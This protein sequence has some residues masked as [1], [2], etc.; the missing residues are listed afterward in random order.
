VR[1]QAPAAGERVVTTTVITLKVLKPSDAAGD[2]TVT[3]GVVPE[4]VCMDLQTAQDTMQAAGF[5]NLRS[6]DA[7]GQG[8]AQLIDRNWVVVAQS[9]RAGSRPPVDTRIVLR[10]VKYGEP[11]GDS[12]CPS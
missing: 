2:A 12:H 1:S 6:E 5:Y 3:H 10:S 8:R 11:T 7:T 4:V 9:A